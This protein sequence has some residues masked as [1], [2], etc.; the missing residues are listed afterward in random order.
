MELSQNGSIPIW[1][2]ED[3]FYNSDEVAL[4]D[5]VP[6]GSVFGALVFSLYATIRE[7]TADIW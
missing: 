1:R 3:F 4:T 7:S 2:T 5:G 6:Q